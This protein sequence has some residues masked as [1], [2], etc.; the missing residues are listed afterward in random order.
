MDISLDEG[1]GPLVLES[2]TRPC[3][4][5]QNISGMGLDAIVRWAAEGDDRSGG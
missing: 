2:N 3:L 5:I 4:E 1:K